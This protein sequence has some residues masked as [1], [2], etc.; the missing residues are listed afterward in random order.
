MK[1]YGVADIVLKI[2][3]VDCEVGVN[4]TEPKRGRGVGSRNILQTK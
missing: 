2:L 4:H 3:T 1:I